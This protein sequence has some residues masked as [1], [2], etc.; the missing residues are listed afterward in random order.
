VQLRS[1]TVS[2]A[3]PLAI[4]RLYE[5]WNERGLPAFSEL[6]SADVEW[7]EPPDVPGGGVHAGKAA[8]I[9]YL[10]SLV[11]T[12]GKFACDVVETTVSDDWVLAALRLH[13]SESR[14]GVPVDVLVFHL[15]RLRDGQVTRVEAFLS[16]EQADAAL[17]AG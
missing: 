14:S 11:E 15:H 13:G 1:G 12:M 5:V 2:E 16:R 3:D 7:Q 17:A 9:E 10:G 4:E 6:L 8:V